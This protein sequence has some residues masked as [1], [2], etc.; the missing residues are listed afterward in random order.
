M[1]KNKGGR[2]KLTKRNE[3]VCRLRIKEKL[4]YKEIASVMKLTPSNV[5]HILE[6]H[7]TTYLQGIDKT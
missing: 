2:P 6:R 5:L 4:D 7:L 1:T 3:L